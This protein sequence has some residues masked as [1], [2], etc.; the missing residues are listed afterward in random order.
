MD[1]THNSPNSGFNSLHAGVNET[2][3]IT[4][5]LRSQV[6][7]ANAN[8]D[9]NV[10]ANAAAFQARRSTGGSRGWGG[11]LFDEPS[12]S[13]DVATTALGACYAIILD[14]VHELLTPESR[15]GVGTPVLGPGGVGLPQAVRDR[16]QGWFRSR[17]STKPFAYK[18]TGQ[19]EKPPPCTVVSLKGTHGFV[20]SLDIYTEHFLGSQVREEM[21]DRAI[22]E[23]LLSEDEFLHER[24]YK[25]LF[26]RDK[27]RCYIRDHGSRPKREFFSEIR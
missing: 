5:K 9:P 20:E 17:K 14:T 16:D 11:A 21:A 26:G 8:D 24:L 7:A 1:T 2:K 19:R 23:A 25:D 6:F 27:E 3:T 12:I 15:I 18:Q 22:S 10:A 4:W 13:V